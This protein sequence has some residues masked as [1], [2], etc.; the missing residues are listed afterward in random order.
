MESDKIV[1]RRVNASKEVESR[2]VLRVPPQVVNMMV[3][4]IITHLDMIYYNTKY[5]LY[6]LRRLVPT[7][8]VHS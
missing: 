7:V 8:C 3:E 1:V 5:N 4:N 6:H 2:V